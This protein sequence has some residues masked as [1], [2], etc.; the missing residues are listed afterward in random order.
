VLSES[1]AKKYFG[2]ADPLGKMLLI[3]GKDRAYVTG[4]M[5]DI[6]HNSHLRVDIL[7]SL[8]TLLKV[9]NPDLATR[10]ISARASSYVLLHQNT[11]ASSLQQQLPA[12]VE[13]HYDQ[14][15]FQ[16][17]LL[18]EPLKE[19]YLHGKP[20]GSR[21]GSAITGNPDTLYILS[22]VAGFVLLIAAFNFVNLTTSFSLQRAKEI[23]VRK[24][25][26]A[27]KGQLIVQFLSD[28]VLLS[29]S[30]CALS[31]ML[32]ILLMPFFQQL[33]G[34]VIEFSLLKNISDIGWFALLALAIGVLS[35]I[36]PAFFLSGF[37]PVS[38]LKGKLISTSKGIGLRRSLV[39]L[40]FSISIILVVATLVVFQQLFYMQTQQ[41]GFKKDHR[42]VIDFQFDLNVKKHAETI[43]EQLT[44]L[45]GVTEASISSCIPGRSNHKLDTEL[46]NADNTIQ[47]SRLDAYFVDPDFFRQYAIEVIA[48][49]PFSKE[50]ATDSAQAMMVNEATVK[51][52]GYQRAED[53]L[54]KKF[55]QYGRIG[56]IIG[57]VR[58]F[59]F[60][61]FREEVQPLTFQMGDMETFLSLTVSDI[62]P[63][64]ILTNIEKKWNEVGGGIPM[65]W[66][67]GD[68]AYDAQYVPEERFGKL[69]L[70]FAALAIVLSCLGLVGLT[71]FSTVQRTK[72]IGIRKVLGS[73]V[74]GILGVLSKDFLRLIIVAVV[75]AIPVSWFS[76]NRWLEGFAYRI[77]ISWW[78]FVV[79]GLTVVVVAFASISYQTLKAANA[80]PIKSLRSE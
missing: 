53:V 39:L 74:S 4:V 65:I 3:N 61:S 27:T 76:M 18:L 78:L 22:I 42:V 71:A 45:P 19:V 73:S 26:G 41:L 66:F 20:R 63:A 36:Y 35:G 44:G 50:I 30:A 10:W 59:H 6:P 34:K 38:S 64:P 48:G 7:L 1:S 25:L 75:I 12:F 17:T 56:I 60:R 5:K 57:V 33:S 21:S 14:H 28:A 79:A 72:E 13:K 2:D 67:F 77:T 11:S 69:F 58:D 62:N 8:F 55:A 16:Y 29:L 49:R 51:S 31:I 43:K 80:N 70:T 24:V 23:G 47:A 9:W 32:V 37:N 46:E 68:D 15:E 52:L 54:G 40:Q